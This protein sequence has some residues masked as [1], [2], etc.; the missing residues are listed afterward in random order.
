MNIQIYS[1]KRL[2]ASIPTQTFL[3]DDIFPYL[4]SPASV[5]IG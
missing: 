3:K 1:V 2:L 4:Y 5:Y